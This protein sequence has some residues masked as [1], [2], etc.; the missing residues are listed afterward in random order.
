MSL[1]FVTR[2]SQGTHDKVSGRFQSW[3]V[4]NYRDMQQ[5]GTYV[6]MFGVLWT[7]LSRSRLCLVTQPRSS[8]KRRSVAWL[9]AARE[10][11]S[12]LTRPQSS[13]FGSHTW[14]R[15]SRGVMGRMKTK[16]RD[17][18]LILI[19]KVALAHFSYF[20]FTENCV[21]YGWL[22]YYWTDARPETKNQFLDGLKPGN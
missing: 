2:S 20:L 11:R 19:R 14:P 16:G 1:A 18:C 5:R 4:I 22:I 3:T 13:V 10:T 6:R 7:R 9:T 21:S 8:P 12:S 17:D 15:G